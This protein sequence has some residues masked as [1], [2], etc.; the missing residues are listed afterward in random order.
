[1]SRRTAASRTGVRLPRYILA[2]NFS[3]RVPCLEYAGDDVLFQR[4]IDLVPHHHRGNQ[5]CAAGIFAGVS[6]ASNIFAGQGVLQAGI[7]GDKRDPQFGPTFFVKTAA[8][9]NI[10]YVWYTTINTSDISSAFKQLLAPGV[11]ASFRRSHTPISHVALCP[12]T[13][14]DAI[15]CARAV[16]SDGRRGGFACDRHPRWTPVRCPD[17]PHAQQSGHSHFRQPHSERG[18]RIANS[19]GGHGYRSERRDRVAGA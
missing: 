5:A 6:T 2:S 11:R 13:P 17:R 8:E 18:S 16:T 9:V 14:A 3:L 10:A 12:C 7:A 15:A 4:L 19:R 1:C